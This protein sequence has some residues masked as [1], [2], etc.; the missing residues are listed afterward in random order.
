[1]NLFR[2]LIPCA[3]QRS[4][5]TGDE[6]MTGR[7]GASA[8][9]PTGEA[10]SR[11]GSTTQ[12]ARLSAGFQTGLAPS[13]TSDQLSVVVRERK[14]KVTGFATLRKKFIRRRRSS[15]A[16]DHGRVLRELVAEWGPLEVGALLEEYEALAALKDLS[17]QAELARPPAATYK[18]D[19]STLYDFKYCTDVDLVFRGVCFPVHRALLSARCPY[20]RDLLAGCP[21]YGA[22]IC[23]ELRTPGVDVQMFSALLRYLYTG[24]ICTHDGTLDLSLLRRL[25]EEFGTPNPLEHDLCYLLETGDYAD[26]A[27]VFT[28]D[29][30]GS[31]GSGSSGEYQRPDSGSSEYGFRPKLELPCHK[32]IL[33][34]RSPF[35]RNLIQRRTRSGEEH[36]ER[37]L[38]IPTRIVLDECVI[39]KRYAK[40]LLHAVY[41]DTVDLS[42]ILR[43]SGCGSGAGSLGEVQALTHTGRTRPS[44]LEEAMELYQIG[45]FLELDI[46]AQ[47][48]EDLILEWLSLESLPTVLRWGSQPHGSAWVHRQA[49]HYLREEFQ[50]VAQSPVLHQLDKTHL[51]DAL[52]SHF[53]Q[54]S[55]LEVLQAVLK[56][57]EHELIRRMEDREPNLLSHTAHSVTRKGVKKRDLSDVELREI[58]SELLPLVRMDHVLPP[59]SDVL[60]Q[61]IRRGLVSTPP[62]HMIG[63]D[64]EN[65]RANAWI[66]G[67]K[68]NGL[69]IKAQLDDHLVQD[70][71]LIR[72]RRAP[73][74]PDI[75]DT[76]Y[77]VED[78]PRPHG[79]A[80]V[81]V[82]E[83]NMEINVH[84]Q[85]ISI[86]SVPDSATM[87]AMLKRE[88][89]LRQSPS[90]Q[91]AIALPLSSR[92]E[93]NRQI[94]LRVVREFNLPDAV[95]DLLENAACY[96]KP[97]G[98]P[99]C[100]GG[101]PPCFG[102]NMTFPR[103]PGSAYT[104][105]HEL[106]AVVT[107]GDAYR[108]HGEPESS[109]CSDGHLSDIMPDVAMAT[110]SF[111]QLQ[112]QEQQELELDL[113][114]G[115]SHLHN[116]LSPPPPHP[117]HP[118]LS[119]PLPTGGYHRYLGGPGPP[120]PYSHHRPS[121]GHM[122]SGPYHTGPP[123]FI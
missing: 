9:N 64:R 94:R 44:P 68:N 75:P 65:L 8:S 19:L 101:L 52:S 55:E 95:A 96:W 2:A 39:P 62:S 58:L 26:A 60:N 82:Y 41:L 28:S 87:T 109:S 46:L 31:S 88:Q 80:G 113:G 35:F 40:V 30:N 5:W 110:A 77:M 91:R 20:F 14:K 11:V 47:G 79:T 76:L 49:L 50:A 13:G 29:G 119:H 51:I 69:F 18:Q 104:V 61:A 32:A 71:Q 118:L 100:S 34:A 99:P 6:R 98:P 53:L 45:R 56:W 24:D 43:G 59:S 73:Y 3:L 84:R 114:D 7:M 107:E 36:T 72:L 108:G 74:S 37:A 1:M 111:G 70:V 89:K 66:R 86:S 117:V 123:R 78:K 15:K 90:C 22:R 16:C 103:G 33:S 121:P 102:R 12:A 93:I 112:L 57:G 10:Q 105:R 48:C 92:H 85:A 54:A 23:L 97:P 116:P 122:G 27:L 38:H 21:G 67:G 120:P 25:G 106:P 17:V 115:T 4:C 83:H 81:D 63:D 42:L